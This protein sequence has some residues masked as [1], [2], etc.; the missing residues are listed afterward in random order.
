VTPLV[1][2]FYKTI[3]VEAGYRSNDHVLVNWFLQF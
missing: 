3:L 2:F 1:R